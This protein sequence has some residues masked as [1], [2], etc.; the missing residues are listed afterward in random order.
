MNN[1]NKLT[2]PD[3][4]SDHYL[5]IEKDWLHWRKLW[6]SKSGNQG[7]FRRSCTVLSRKFKVL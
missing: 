4:D 1:V 6:S 3:V 2:G 5:L 7:G